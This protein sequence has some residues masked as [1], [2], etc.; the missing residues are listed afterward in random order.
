MGGRRNG[1]RY[2]LSGRAEGQAESRHLHLLAARRDDGGF[3][4][5]SQ[6]RGAVGTEFI[7]VGDFVLA[8]GTSRVKVVFA[9]GAEI[10]A[11]GN[12][13]GALRALVG[14]RIANE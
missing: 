3:G 12:G 7:G 10:K 6:F 14:K 8:L 5:V 11:R 1:D 13:R 4:G 2:G 9:I